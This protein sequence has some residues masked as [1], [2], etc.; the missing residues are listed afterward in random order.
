M[1][2]ADRLDQAIKT[3][4]NPICAGLD[5]RFDQIPK[6]LAEPLVKKYGRTPEAVAE[7]FIAFNKAIIDAVA[8]IVPV[9]KPQI[10]FYEEYGWQ[11]I[12]AYE[13]TVRY[14]REK[15]LL[16]I[17]DAKRGDIGAT[18]AAY[19]RAHI[20][21]RI[22]AKDGGFEADALTVNPYMGA[23]TLDPFLELCASGPGRG[24]FVLVKTSNPG[25]GDLQ[26]VVTASIETVSERVAKMVH[27]LGEKHMGKCGLSAVGAV[28][29]ATYP[30]QAEHLRT[31]MPHTYLLIP[32]YGA[33]GASAK[34]AVA[35][36]T[37]DGRGA[38][39]N[40]SRLLIF[41]Y[42]QEPYAAKFGERDFAGAARAASLKMAE[43]LKAAL[44]ERAK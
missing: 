10:A 6:S 19:A 25:S 21:D 34:D 41:A 7:V 32:G 36:F 13:A 9:C 42:K 27:T 3:K 29:G 14:A 28:V 23:D 44:A 20:G 40:N 31:L 24:I 33:Q 4:G 2:F 18:A 38:I 43:E 37:A 17:S 11:G 12:R 35:G 8:D 39:V 30:E 15:G 5:P 26:D 1:N 22:D 16:V